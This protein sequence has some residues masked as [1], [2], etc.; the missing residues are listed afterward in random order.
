MKRR[1]RRKLEETLRQA[2]EVTRWSGQS[3]PE[4]LAPAGVVPREV[5]VATWADFPTGRLASAR[6]AYRVEDLIIDGGIVDEVN[7]FVA[8]ASKAVGKPVT[9]LAATP[10]PPHN[11]PPS[12][13]ADVAPK[14]PLNA[15]PTPPGSDDP[16]VAF[17]P[18]AEQ[19]DPFAP[20]NDG[21]VH[22]CPYCGS[23]GVVGRPAD[24]T[25]ECNF[26]NQVFKVFPAK[27]HPF[28]P[29]VVNGQPVDIPGL[30][31]NQDLDTPDEAAG[32]APAPPGAGPTP[33][34]PAGAP[35]AAGGGLERFRVDGAP[36]GATTASGEGLDRFRTAAQSSV[37]YRTAT[38]HELN[39]DSYVA[40]LALLAADSHDEWEQVRR[41][42]V[43]SRSRP[44]A[45]RDSDGNWHLAP[46]GT[47]TTFTFPPAP[48][49]LTASLRAYLAAD[50]DLAGKTCTVGPNAVT[51][52]RC[53]KP[54]VSSFV[55]RDD[56]V[57]YECA[58]HDTSKLFAPDRNSLKPGD[59]V[60]VSHSGVDKHG[61][62]VSVGRTNVRVEVPTYGGSQS[63]VIT[64][65]IS[66][67]RTAALAD[68]ATN[69][70]IGRR[71]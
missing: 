42:V 69:T 63:K 52:E 48:P 43:A 20:T 53:G 37:T 18:M 66:D 33:G 7:A 15:Q 68:L 16:N 55:G 28:Q 17:D 51:G 26:C 47:V 50:D 35:G 3:I 21:K 54:A 32:T 70:I 1:A 23:G 60:M 4:A 36:P 14:P 6:T 12:G 34:A 2:A 38:G 61:T 49:E 58:E 67:V 40:H 57:Y 59:S 39:E 71:V 25:I 10:P 44:V 11:A 62:V 13:A 41:R 29:T 22:A 8:T 31:P 46:G 45:S 19:S 56:N 65:P 64:V 9:V 5:I 24:G 30:G 27:A